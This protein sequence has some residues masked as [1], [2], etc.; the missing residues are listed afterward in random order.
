M[1]GAG[2]QEVDI[3]G[4]NTYQAKTYLDSQLRKTKAYRL[5]VI[6]GYHGGTQLQSFVRK[7]YKGHPKVLRIEVGLNQGETD[8]VL[9]EY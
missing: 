3:H 7:E 1:L 9:K 2:I 5:R 6:H 8:L 4:M